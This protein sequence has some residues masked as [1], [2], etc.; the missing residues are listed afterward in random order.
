MH[1]DEALVTV[2][3]PSGPPLLSCRPLLLMGAPRIVLL[4]GWCGV[5]QGSTDQLR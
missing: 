5:N 4:V 1:G 3:C 2:A